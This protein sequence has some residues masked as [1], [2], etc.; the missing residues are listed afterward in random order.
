MDKKQRVI[1]YLLL[2]VFV[3]MAVSLLVI[4]ERNRRLGE[5]MVL[6][7]FLSYDEA[8][9][10]SRLVP[11]RREIEKA[12]TVEE[13]IRFAIEHLLKGLT[14]AEKE[15]G[16]TNAMAEKAV[17]LNVTIDGDTVY[18]DFSKDI[19]VGGGTEMMTARLVQII[20]TAT[21]FYPVTKVQLLIN[22][23]NIKY[24]SGEGITD[25]DH[26]MDRDTF[27]YDEG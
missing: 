9:Q 10:K 18:L 12:E 7:Y 2:V 8:Q 1:V 6:V 23:K 11:L 13:K 3:A 25:V 24:F 14:D 26:P 19:E 20:Y 21:Q 27:K 22:G 5:T 4:K 16:L 17:L 15:A